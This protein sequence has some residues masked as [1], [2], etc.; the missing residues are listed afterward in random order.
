MP[1]IYINV[2]CS[3]GLEFT[4]CS[5]VETTLIFNGILLCSMIYISYLFSVF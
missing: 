3:C 5:V 2:N 1:V 4:K